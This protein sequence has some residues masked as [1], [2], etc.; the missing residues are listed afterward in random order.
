MQ[1]LQPLPGI[2]RARQEV[3]QLEAGCE[4]QGQR[5]ECQRGRC[6]CAAVRDGPV[7]TSSMIL[8]VHHVMAGAGEGEKGVSVALVAKAGEGRRR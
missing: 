2:G 7:H 6:A 8:A 5:I 1:L 3:R 4:R